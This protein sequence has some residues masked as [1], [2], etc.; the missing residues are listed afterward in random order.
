MQRDRQQPGTAH[1]PTDSQSPGPRPGAAVIAHGVVGTSG[2]D[3]K[4]WQWLL[5]TAPGVPL[6]PVMFDLL[7]SP[8][9]P[10]NTPF[11][12]P[13]PGA[14]PVPDAAGGAGVQPAV[15]GAGAGGGQRHGVHGTLLHAAHWPGVQ[16]GAWQGGWPGRARRQGEA[17]ALILS[18]TNWP[19][20]TADSLWHCYCKCNSRGVVP[21]VYSTSTS[22]STSTVGLW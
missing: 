11:P 13:P 15:G 2:L 6:P 17:G 19:R 12:F 7:S 4:P 16:G 20:M 21:G 3:A 5:G 18:V 8:H 1:R 9:H 22:T 10:P 14:A